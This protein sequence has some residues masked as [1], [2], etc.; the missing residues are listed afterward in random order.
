[1][2]GCYISFYNIRYTI[3]IYPLERQSD[4]VEKTTVCRVRGRRFDYRSQ[5]ILFTGRYQPSSGKECN[6]HLPL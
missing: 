1:M 2:M 4:R 6:R 5:A 3:F